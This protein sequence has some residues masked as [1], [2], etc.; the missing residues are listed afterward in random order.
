M[1]RSEAVIKF[2]NNLYDLFTETLKSII[3]VRK[4]VS[5]Y[6][7]RFFIGLEYCYIFIRDRF[8]SDIGNGHRIQSFFK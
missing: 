3:H 6:K 7:T 4:H 2:S 8:S 1:F 5:D